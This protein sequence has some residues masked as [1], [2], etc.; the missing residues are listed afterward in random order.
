MTT[1][2][3]STAVITFPAHRAAPPTGLYS[4]PR[5]GFLRWHVGRHAPRRRP[6]LRSAAMTTWNPVAFWM[7]VLLAV[8]LFAIDLVVVLY[9]REATG[10]FA[11]GVR[12]IFAVVFGMV[13][14]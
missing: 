10:S 2:D 14:G 13:T 1:I 12:D 3:D 5:P 8:L 9:A 11:G 4:G 7:F 6:T